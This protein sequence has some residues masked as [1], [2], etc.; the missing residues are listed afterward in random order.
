MNRRGFL[1]S[2]FAAC[3]APAIVRADSLMRVVPLQTGTVSI[4]GRQVPLQ[5]APEIVTVDPKY[6]FTRDSGFVLLDDT[7]I[8]RIVYSHHTPRICLP[9]AR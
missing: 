8:L 4:F 1:A 2:M 3:A 9:T 5:Y 7:G 6:W